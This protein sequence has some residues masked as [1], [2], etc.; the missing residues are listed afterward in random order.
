MASTDTNTPATATPAQAAPA[1]A[2]PTTAAPPA[3]LDHP[4]WR[5]ALFLLAASII[6][7]SQ[8]LGQGFLFA[9]TRQIAG[10]IGASQTQ[11]TWL[12]VAYMAPR[13]SLPLLLIKM[14]T[15]FGLRKFALWSVVAYV[16]ATVLG[17]FVDDLHSAIVI[18]FFTGIAAAPLTSLAVLYMLEALPPAKKLSVGLTGALTVIMLGTPLGRALT[19]SLWDIGG[20]EATKFLV[21]GL[22]FLSIPFI[23]YLPLSHAPR[24]KV[25]HPLDLV[26]YAGIALGFAGIAAV[27]TWGTT[28]WWTNGLWLGVVLAGSLAALTAAAMLE[29][30]RDT[31]LIDIRWIATPE[32]LHLTGVLLLFRIVLSEQSVGSPYLFMSLGLGNEQMAPL[33]WVI[34]AFTLVG[35]FL[36][37]A[38]ITP[39]RVPL[40]H[41]AA[42]L[43]LL[44]G[45]LMDS[46]STALTRPEQ[47]FVSQALIATASMLYMPSA[48]AI[49]LMKALAKGPQYL[50]TFVAVFL[51]TQVLGSLIGSGL[52]RTFIQY[53]TAHHSAVL[54]EQLMAGDPMVTSTITQLMNA[55][56]SQITD[57]T[58]RKLQAI[59]TLASQLSTQA[60][61]L[62]YDDV[63]LLLAGVAGTALLLLIGHVAWLKLFPAPAP[64]A[65]AAPQPAAAAPAAG[66]SPS[67]GAAPSAAPATA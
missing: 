13:A 51:S 52:L 18:E 1:Q 2:A 12:M 41:G 35:G 50:L 59:S 32:I 31:P 14:R 57:V 67:T 54:K 60:T 49:G 56:A 8:S 34:S 53:R 26:S 5:I 55:Y 7:L 62:A 63:F 44:T 45:A 33:F 20:W 3:P 47:M 30:S 15:Q 43:M 17:L 22:V 4:N 48:M 42:L 24:M 11:A 58:Q 21:L 25:I 46:H 38:L 65:P 28:D 27:F 6:G 16:I 29:L 39:Q 19:P 9:N 23:L 61:V 40:I 36:C 64:A 37:G 66:S 10:E